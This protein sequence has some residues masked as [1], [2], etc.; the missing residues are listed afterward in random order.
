[1]EVEP[2]LVDHDDAGESL[3]VPRQVRGASVDAQHDLAQYV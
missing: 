1:M 3:G 2:G